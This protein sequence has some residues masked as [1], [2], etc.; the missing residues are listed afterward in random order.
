MRSG[1]LRLISNQ[2]SLIVPCDD[3]L[4]LQAHQKCESLQREVTSVDKIT[5]KDK[6][7]I[8]IVDTRCD[9]LARRPGG[10]LGGGIRGV[11]IVLL[12]LCLDAL[13]LAVSSHLD[14]LPQSRVRNLG[15]R[16]DHVGADDGF[17]TLGRFDGSLARHAAR[18]SEK[19]E[20]IIELA[21]NISTHCDRSDNGLDV[22]FCDM[23]SL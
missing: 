22:A 1:Y 19:L 12:S 4:G 3:S 16:F 17:G 15:R 6:S 10:A 21:M 5:E 13:A 8:R 20:Q 11:I 23:V 18:H 7:H 2:R 14:L 9:F